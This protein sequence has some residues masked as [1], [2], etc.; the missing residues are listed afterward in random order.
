MKA[1]LNLCRKATNNRGVIF[2]WGD[3]ASLAGESLF[4]W[5]R[6]CHVT[7]SPERHY[8]SRGDSVSGRIYIVTPEPL[9]S[10]PK[11]FRQINTPWTWTVLRRLLA[12]EGF[13]TRNSQLLSIGEFN[14]DLEGSTSS[15]TFSFLDLLFKFGL[16]QNFS[17]HT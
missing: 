4:Q 3:F 16:L 9:W 11:M 6:L 12:L 14:I 13:I 2:A 15:Y 10:S 1:Y 17:P 7:E 8:F 5:Q